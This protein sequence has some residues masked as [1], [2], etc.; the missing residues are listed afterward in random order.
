MAMLGRTHDAASLASTA[1]VDLIG[2][3]PQS[4]RLA[5]ARRLAERQ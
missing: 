4:P 2:Q 3:H 1:L 5:Q